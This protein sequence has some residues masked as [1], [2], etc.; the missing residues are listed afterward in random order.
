VV[1]DVNRHLLGNGLER[2]RPTEGQVLSLGLPHRV[3]EVFGPLNVDA[4]ALHLKAFEDVENPLTVFFIFR[5]AAEHFFLESCFLGGQHFTA[6][7]MTS[8]YF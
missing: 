8:P 4:R 6:F 2:F 5:T 7:H 3:G 1:V